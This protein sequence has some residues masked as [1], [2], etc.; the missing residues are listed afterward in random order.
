MA[1]AWKVNDPAQP[2][3]SSQ[4]KTTKRWAGNCTIIGNNN[5]KFYHAEVQVEN[6]GGRA[7]VYTIYGRVGKTQAAN[8]RYFNS[9]AECEAEFNKL[10]N[11]KKNRKKD[12]YV[13]VELAITAVGSDGAKDIKKAM[14]GINIDKKKVSKSKL[15]SEVQRLVGSWFKNT[16][17]FIKMNLKCELGQLTVEQIEKGRKVL[18]KCKK[19]VNSNLQISEKEYDILTSNFFSLIPHVLPHKIR[20]EDLR[21]NSLD[22]IIKKEETLDTFLD[23]K[24]IS[25]VIGSNSID[26]KYKSLDAKIE[27]I[28]PASPEFKWI[29]QTVHGTR[30]SNHRFLGKIKVHNIF[31]LQ[32]NNEYNL[33]T[34]RAV[35]IASK[36]Q[37]K[38]FVWPDILRRYGLERCDYESKEESELFKRANILPLF[39]GTRTENCSGIIKRGLLIR[40]S[41]AVHTGSMFGDGSYFGNFS[42]SCSYSSCR[43]TYWAR[44]NSDRGYVFLA[45]VCLGSQKIVE[46]SGY[47]TVNN[48]KPHHSIW[49]KAGR[50][51]YND[52]FVTYYPSGNNQQFNLRYILEVET[53]A[54]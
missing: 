42:K 12:P 33:F 34:N 24:N 43:G 47:Y 10:V 4:Y 26:E 19:K 6:S 40:P 3:F 44:G 49:A 52:E 30:A 27:W 9:E 7:R 22:R 28:N 15:H 41:G 5:N 37:N 50:S 29:E 11:K 1:K 31:K 48:I 23:T 39:H 36:R 53:Q 46:T 17:N 16:D 13:E 54:K 25:S 45:D 32:R 18:D 8:Y 14:T 51:L 20:P 21:L 35:Q 2:D 38:D